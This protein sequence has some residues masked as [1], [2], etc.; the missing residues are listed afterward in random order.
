LTVPSSFLIL[1]Y[2][3]KEKKMRRREK[4]MFLAQ[5]ANERK[6]SAEPNIWLEK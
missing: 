3:H 2:T 6:K 4:K 1:N 5:S